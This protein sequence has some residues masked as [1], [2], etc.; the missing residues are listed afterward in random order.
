M[1]EDFYNPY[2]FIPATGK[3]GPNPTPTIDFAEIKKGETGIRHD[4]WLQT[5]KSGRIV[6]SL[7]LKTPTVVGNQHEPLDTGESLVHPYRIGGDDDWD[8]P[9]ERRKGELAIPANSLR[10]MVASVAE[11]LSQSALRVLEEEVYSVRKAVRD[12]PLSALGYLRKEVRNPGPDRYYLRPLTLPTIKISRNPFIPRQWTS[13]LPKSANLMHW[14]GAYVDGY[15]KR[16]GEETLQYIPTKFLDNHKPSC[17]R[18]PFST[19]YY[20]RLARS[21][22]NKPLTERLDLEHAALKVKEVTSKE[23]FVTYFLLGQRISKDDIITQEEFNQ[24]GGEQKHYTRGIL[25]VL[26]IDGRDKDIPTTKH[27]E[28]FIPWPEEKEKQAF[29]IEISEPVIEKFVKI[30]RKRHKEDERLPFLPKGYADGENS[31]ERYLSDGDLI[32][33]NLELNGEVTEISYSSIWRQAKAGT[34]HDAFAKID[35][36][37]LPWKFGGRTHLTPAEWIFGVVDGQK[38]VVKD[39][40]SY[41][42]ASRVRFSDARGAEPGK[43]ELLKPA[44]AP[45]KGFQLKILSSPKPPS[46]AMYFK[47]G[48]EITKTTLDLEK[49][50]PNGRKYYLPHKIE[51]LEWESQHTG[52]NKQKVRCW[53]LRENQTFY[54]HIDFDNLADA[55]L[56]LL[57]TALRPGEDYI[58]RLGLGKPLGLGCVTVQPL[59]VFLLDRVARYS[60]EALDIGARRYAFQI[61]LAWDPAAARRYEQESA[62]LGLEK[63]EFKPDKSLIDPD[64]LD[65]L[66]T[67]GSLKSQKPGT[68][69]HYPYCTA[70][71]ITREAEGYEWFV[72]NDKCEAGQRQGLAL[73]EKGRELKPLRTH[74]RPKK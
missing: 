2:Q 26:G 46:P 30:A 49:H 57:L 60:P 69:I 65:L 66:N 17:A 5:R 18:Y 7:T 70:D 63:A 71:Q 20:A 36:N 23:G 8:L 73:V 43:I 54:F 58:H 68:R 4:L 10:G 27:H 37:L 61:P 1:A 25:Y 40:K 41:N 13:L 22:K 44:A 21:L 15:E 11:T 14:L 38:K 48:R 72:A 24:K 29:E 35:K 74:P 3:C 51:R 45:E 39:P 52:D 53:P 64:T 59:G 50:R 16:Q 33:F 9:E 34:I 12:A 42:L 19:F 55:E 67:V 28:R 32:Y 47:E 62:S 31:I 56:E 6:C